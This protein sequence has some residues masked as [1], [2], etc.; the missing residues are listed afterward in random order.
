MFSKSDSKTRL[1]WG[2]LLLQEFDLEIKDKKGVKN[3]VANHLSRLENEEV[4]KNKDNITETFLDEQLMAISERPWF[5]DMANYK[6]I[7]VGPEEYTWQQRKCFY[8]KANF[9][10][11][12]DSYLFKR[13]PDGLLHRF[14]ASREAGR[15]M[16]HCHS[17]VY[18]GHHNGERR[19]AKNLQSGVWLPTLFDECKL[20]V[21]TCPECNKTSNIS[22]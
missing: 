16:W 4:T 9:Y 6:A 14:V 11:W 2:V 13:I 17:S 22:K 20:Y 21:S 12:D 18:R 5:V 19:D 1:L 3:M 8:K 10:L 7:N 15:I